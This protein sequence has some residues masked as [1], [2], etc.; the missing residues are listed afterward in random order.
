MTS[1]LKVL[2]AELYSSGMV[3]QSLLC[4]TEGT[5]PSFGSLER[6]TERDNKSNKFLFVFEIILGEHIHPL[7]N[8]LLVLDNEHLDKLTN[9]I[10]YGRNI[11]RV[12]I[13]VPFLKS[14]AQWMMQ[15][16][17]MCKSDSTS[18]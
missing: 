7:N 5:E 4:Q 12:C 18:S 17:T 3:S 9:S 2:L 11:S 10:K 16:I 14:I 15:Y 8:F 1:A 6:G 13:R